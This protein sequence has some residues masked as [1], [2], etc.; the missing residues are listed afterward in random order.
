M[1]ILATVALEY[2]VEQLEKTVSEM[3]AGLEMFARTLR[4]AATWGYDWT[5]GNS[6]ADRAKG[7]ALEEV[8]DAIDA[9]FDIDSKKKVTP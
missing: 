7:K 9:A 4:S 8:A 5:N 3:R 2:R 1:T 6:D